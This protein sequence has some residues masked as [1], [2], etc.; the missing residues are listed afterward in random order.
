MNVFYKATL[1]TMKKNR[2]RTLVTIL[3]VILSAAMVCAVTTIVS[4]LR[5]FYVNRTIYETGDWY[6]MVEEADGTLREKLSGDGRISQV[7]SA[8]I[9]GYSQSD[10]KNEDKPY[11]YLLGADETFFSVMPVHYTG[12]LPQNQGEILVPEHYLSMGNGGAS[13][14][15]GDTLTLSLGERVSEGYPLD[16]SNPYVEEESLKVRATATYTVVGF[17]ERPDFEDYSA[18]GY[19]FL[20][21]PEAD[22]LQQ[23]T[24]YYKTDRVEDLEQVMSD[25]EISEETTNWNL[26]AAYGS[27]KYDNFFQVLSGFAV[28]LIVLIMVGSVSL[29]Y[30]AFSISVSERTRQFGLLR[31][32][33]ATRKQLRRSVFFEAAV[34]SAVGIPIGVACGIGGIWVTL[35]LLEGKFQSLFFSSVLVELHVSYL[36]VA[37]AVAVSLITVAASVWIPAKRATMVTAIEAIRQSKEIRRGERDVKVSRLTRKLFG[38]EGILAKKHFRRN[39]SRYRATVVSLTLSVALFISASTFCMY[40]TSTVDQTIT[41]RNYDVACF[42]DGVDPEAAF[43]MLLDA[44][45]VTQGVYLQE[46]WQTLLVTS[47]QMDESFVSFLRKSEESNTVVGSSGEIPPELLDSTTPV[48]ISA[49]VCYV[50][51]ATYRAFLERQGLDTG[52]YLD[53]EDP[54]PL[55]YSRGTGVYY[56]LGEDGNQR[57]TTDYTLLKPSVTQVQ[58]RIEQTIEGYYY[59]GTENQIRDAETGEEMPSRAVDTFYHLET[60]EQLQLPTKSAPISLGAHVT[61]VPMGIEE[62][63]DPTC[64]L[65]YPYSAAP[66]GTLNSVVG[67]FTSSSHRETVADMEKLLLENGLYT[68]S[69]QVFDVQEAE[70]ADR[71]LIVIINVF[72]YGFIV[73]ISLISAANVFNTISTNIALRRREFAMLRSVGMTRGGLNRM[74]NYECLLY[75]LRS[76]LFGLPLAGLTSLWIYRTAVGAIGGG[77]RLPWG[78]IAV[79]VCSVFVVVFVTMLYAM[80]KIKGENPIDALKNENI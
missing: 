13:V 9:L 78:A 43:P 68:G 69:G 14:Q 31:S 8:Q 77:F 36:A 15:L 58:T 74:M 12:E 60:G 6:G 3:G 5:E 76:L 37:I 72:S 30:S 26:L 79:A 47:E 27:F 75:G 39:R 52:L 24:L 35:K 80:G 11:I 48:A 53:T 21:V 50:D 59:S 22:G 7:A 55:V 54:L 51:D 4:S 65:M 17:Y 18:P 29:I 46:C 62:P 56:V 25:Y 42:L 19:T 1:A 20:T 40:L 57:M 44:R 61:E 2:V 32:V 67:Y 45:G 63:G 41:R 34:V 71:N 28:I 38:L 73:L 10:S 49:R 70:S 33:G 66:E 64:I 23:Y 16:N